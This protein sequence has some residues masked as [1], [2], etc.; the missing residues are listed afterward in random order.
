[1]RWERQETNLPLAVAPD[2]N[3]ALHAVA[4]R[5]PVPVEEEAPS[6]A[7]GRH[8]L[9]IRQI[10]SDRHA[11]VVDV[12]LEMGTTAGEP[13]LSAVAQVAWLVQHRVVNV[14]TAAGDGLDD[15]RARGFEDLAKVL[16]GRTGLPGWQARGVGAALRSGTR[17]LLAGGAGC[18]R[19]GGRRVGGRGRG[20]VARPGGSGVASGEEQRANCGESE[21]GLGDTHVA[22]FREL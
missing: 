18:G 22:S 21:D 16:T 9:V 13:H 1:M 15:R 5:E 12:V 17:R 4:D 10:S 6:S 19:A 20:A 2:V 11:E 3:E 8:G 7:V 14:G